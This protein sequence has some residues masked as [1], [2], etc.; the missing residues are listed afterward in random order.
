[1]AELKYSKDGRL[2]FT[3]EMKKEYTVLMPMMLPVH[4]TLLRNCFRLEGFNI[5][6]LT[7]N[8]QQIIEEGLK[9]VHNDTCYP[10]LLVVGQFIDALK[11]GKYDVDKTALII[12]QT[13]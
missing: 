8:H 5:E 7:T 12:T 13:G 1:M 11:S 10:A 2:L 3:R 9:N 4:F 6:L